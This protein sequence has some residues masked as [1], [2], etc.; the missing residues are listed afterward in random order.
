MLYDVRVMVDHSG[1]HATD[2]VTGSKRYALERAATL[3][4]R[5]QAAGVVDINGRIHA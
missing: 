2:T 4:A 3:N 5:G 1:H